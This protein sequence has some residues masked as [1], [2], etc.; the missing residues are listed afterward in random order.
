MKAKT[1]FAA[2]FLVLL[3]ALFAFAQK[4][5]N[6]VPSPGVPVGGW[7]VTYYLSSN[8]SKHLLIMQFSDGTALFYISGP[9]TTVQPLPSY[10]AVWSKPTPDS[11]S[12]SSE[13]Q[14]PVG[15]FFRETGTLILKGDLPGAGAMTGRAMFVGDTPDPANPTGFMIKTGTFTA[16]SVPVIARDK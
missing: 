13:V 7:D 3:C 2:A 14:L 11:L 16:F 8:V 10:H 6:N 15:S 9:R 5:T 12:F 4:T 1:G